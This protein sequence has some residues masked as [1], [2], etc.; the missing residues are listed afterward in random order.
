[1]Q[2]MFTECQNFN[3][4]ITSW[5]VTNV[6]DMNR[7]FNNCLLFDQNLSIWNIV[8]VEDMTLMFDNCSLSIENYSNI[9]IGWS[10]LTVKHNVPLGASTK[11]NST[12][13]SARATLTNSPNN[14]IITDDGIL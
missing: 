12:A 7:I 8:N 13:I 11:Y 10:L 14:W 2:N 3:S 6:I 1:M 9:L 5:I 4:D